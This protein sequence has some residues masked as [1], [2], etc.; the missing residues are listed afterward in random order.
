MKKT[1]LVSIS[2]LLIAALA[3][4]MTVAYLTDRE[5]ITNVFT[6]GDV[7]IELTEDFEQG[8]TLTPGVNIKKIPTITNVG[9][10]DAWVWL[11]FSIPANLDYWAPST[12]QGSSANII[13]W[14][15]IGATTEGYVT[16]AR[17]QNAIDKGILPQGTTAADILAA[18]K[19]WNVFNTFVEGT[20]NCYTEEIHGVRYNTYVIPY[21]KAIVPGETTLPSIYNIYMD[22]QIDID[23]NG[24]LYRVVNGNAT[25]VNWNI[26]T[27]GAPIAYVGAYAVQVENFDNVQAAYDAYVGQ[28]G[29][30]NAAFELTIPVEIEND[31]TKLAG[32][33]ATG[34]LLKDVVAA[35]TTFADDAD[36]D[37]FMNGYGITGTIVNGKGDLAISGGE[38]NNDG[39]T[40]ENNGGTAAL[41]DITVKGGSTL[42]YSDVTL[43]GG[44]TVYDNVDIVSAGGAVGAVDGGKVVFNSGK[45]VVD[46]ASTSGRYLFY[47]EGAG[48]EITINGGEFS[49]SSTKN[50]KRAYVYAGAGTTVTINGGTFGPASTRSGYTDGLLG[51]GTIIIKG[52]TFGFNP[53]AW[54]APGYVATQTGSTWTVTA[55]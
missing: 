38:L 51:E 36:V 44:V 31:L 4:G 23:P 2:V 54:V 28:W 30:L 24:D 11:T 47:T 9:K 32:L 49:F 15:P 37:L 8:V 29:K 42:D 14:N 13:H 17:V 26:V 21:N 35:N 12:E 22:P 7:S 55:Q 33:D 1:L 53:S 45:V 46:S 41:E 19:T 52:G 10:N 6:L 3:V 40:F 16:D 39:R 34:I 25:K 48:A 50:Q 43:N 27:D 18:N 20:A 5:S